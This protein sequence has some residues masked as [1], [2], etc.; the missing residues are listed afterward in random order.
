MTRKILTQARLKELLHYD[1]DTGIFTWAKKPSNRI[2]IGSIAGS[3]K[4]KYLYIRINK[5]DH[6]AHRLAW[7]YVNGHQPKHQIDHINHDSKDNR[8]YNLRDVTQSANMQNSSM[9]KRNTSGVTGVAFIRSRGVWEA[10]I[11]ANR[12]FKFLG[13]FNCITA[14]AIARKAAEVKYNFHPNH[15]KTL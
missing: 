6:L 9:H 3:N 7:L 12:K 5:T 11:T 8:I 2:L 4:G 15:G 10:K 1:A 14:A 13:Y